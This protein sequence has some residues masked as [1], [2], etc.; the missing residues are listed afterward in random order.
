MKRT[1]RLR[2]SG[3]IVAAFLALTP[4]LGMGTVASAQSAHEADSFLSD[5]QGLTNGLTPVVDQD[6]FSLTQSDTKIAAQKLNTDPIEN[7]YLEFTVEAPRDGVTDPF[8]FGV[9][10]RD[11]GADYYGLAISSDAGGN[12]PAWGLVLGSSDADPTSADSGDLSADDF[13]T[14]QG[15]DLRCRG[16]GN[17]E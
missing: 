2:W 17:R 9:F 12:G 11:L 10:F 1:G 16:C 15:I 6:S 4:L 5:A 13:P 14:D 3:A 8:D 7:F